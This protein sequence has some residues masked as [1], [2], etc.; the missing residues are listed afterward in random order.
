M[1]QAEYPKFL[2]LMNGVGEYYG[3]AISDTLLDIYLDGLKQYD[4]QDLSRAIKLHLSNPD[5][6]QFF[7]KIA[8]I[9]RHIGGGNQDKALVAWSKVDK[10]VRTVGSHRSIVFDDPVIHAVIQDMGG[11]IDFGMCDLSE[12]PFRQN[13]FIKRY[14]GFM[15]R[16]GVGKDYPAKFL[17]SADMHNR[18]LGLV[19]NGRETVLIGDHSKAMDVLKLGGDS[20]KK[21]P[22]IMLSEHTKAISNADIR[23]IKSK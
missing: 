20:S 10:A 8:D 11:W 21:N 22:V 2:E 9:T 3:K 16:G 4:Y 13:E 19:D 23:L 1:K 7:P 12:W 18:Q 17:G 15:D 6:G 5:G 14:K